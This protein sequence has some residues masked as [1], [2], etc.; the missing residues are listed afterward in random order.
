MRAGLEARGEPFT[1]H[2]AHVELAGFTLPLLPLAQ[3][4]ARAPRES[5]P[6]RVAAELERRRAEQKLGIELDA[7]R[8]DFEKARP[9]LKLRVQRVETVGPNAISAPIASNLRAVLV[10]D[11]PS[12]ITPVRPADLA[13]WEKPADVLVGVALENVK[14]GEQVELKPMEIA[15]ARVFAVSG[16]SVFVATLGLAAEDLLGKP[17]PFGALVAMPSAHIL[18]CHA[19]ADARSLKALEAMAA[20]SLQAFESGPSPLCPDLFWKRADRF[21]ALPVHRENAQV[22]CELPREFDE[23]VV[24]GFA[25]PG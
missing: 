23:Q 5:W 20:G 25:S 16:R 21:V 18:L 1:L 24:Q 3:E 10:L 17:T 22:K 12:F 11:L 14:A 15:G 6:A 2:D 9:A 8:G 7:V 4:C 13:A 19:L